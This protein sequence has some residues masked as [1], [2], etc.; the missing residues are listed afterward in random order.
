MLGNWLDRIDAA[1]STRRHPACGSSAGFPSVQPYVEQSRIAVVPLL[2]GAG[3]KR[4]VIQS[5]MAGTPV[6]T[7]PVGAEGLDLVQGEHALIAAD[8][9][10]LAAGITRLL[11][12]DDLWHQLAA[13][14][15]RHVELRHGVDLVERRFGEIIDAVM[16]RRSRA[17]VVDADGPEAGSTDDAIRRRIQTIGAPG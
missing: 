11:T 7:T 16:A 3:V 10:D 2:H 12:E 17:S 13:A 9:A 4:K 14:G 8:A 5:M 6:V 1:T 15:A